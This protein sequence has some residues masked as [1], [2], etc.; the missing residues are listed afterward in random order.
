MKNEKGNSTLLT[1]RTLRLGLVICVV[2]L[3]Y[4][5]SAF[6]QTPGTYPDNTYPGGSKEVG[7]TVETKDTSGNKVLLNAIG[8]SDSNKVIRELHLTH[9]DPVTKKVVSQSDWY[10]DCK[11][12]LT[13]SREVK[14]DQLGNEIY[15]KEEKFKDGKQTSGSERGTDQNGKKF[16]RSYNPKTGK[17]EDVDVAFEAPS[18]ISAPRDTSVCPINTYANQIFVGFNLIHEDSKPDNFNNPGLNFSFTH[19]FE[20]DTTKNSALPHIAVRA[21]FNVNREDSTPDNFNTYGFDFSF[22]HNF[23]RDN[24][25]NSAISHRVGVTADFNMNF[26]KLNGVDLTK[27]SVLGGATFRLLPTMSD[28]V[29]K[30]NITAHVLF[31]ISHLKSSVGSVSTSDNSFTTKLGG[32]LDVNV[33]PRIFIR[34]IEIDYAPTHFNGSWQNNVQFTFGAGYRWGHTGSTDVNIPKGP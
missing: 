25:K 28:A 3:A 20:R 32:A 30:A 9:T 8:I 23:V 19:N 31:G 14:Y 12:K 21:D 7:K 1:P 15:R 11:G 34:A 13:S 18:E 29:G 4:S 26:R 10:Y 22:T 6:A 27:T 2:L 16:K 24:T 33:T 17:Y 5:V